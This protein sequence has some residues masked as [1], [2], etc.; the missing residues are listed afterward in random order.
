[1]VVDRGSSGSQLR[2]G[3]DGKP[4]QDRRKGQH[5]QQQ[6]PGE[7]AFATIARYG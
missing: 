5:K 1:M 4:R 3:G 6:R 7:Q 2:F